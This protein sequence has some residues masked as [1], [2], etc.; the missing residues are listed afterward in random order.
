MDFWRDWS[1]NGPISELKRSWLGK[2]LMLRSNW[3]MYSTF[4]RCLGLWR[5]SRDDF[6]R[7]PQF[8]PFIFTYFPYTTPQLH[9]SLVQYS[10]LS[11]SIVFFSVMAKISWAENFLDF[12]EIVKSIIFPKEIHQIPCD[13]PKFFACGGPN[14]LK[15]K[16]F[17]DF[18]N[19]LGPP[20]NFLG[21]VKWDSHKKKLYWW[22]V[23]T[24]VQ[25][26]LT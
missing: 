7:S 1:S 16:H 2:R 5:R 8:F 21:N 26:S 3:G 25:W 6:W 24:L 22:G 13:F 14:F 11:D 23:L 18:Q 10:R 20:E 12:P 9:E 4:S 19:F 17:S 15:S